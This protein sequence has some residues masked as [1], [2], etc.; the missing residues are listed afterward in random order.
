MIIYRNAIETD[1]DKIYE[2]WL[3]GLNFS[4]DININ[5]IDKA[6]FR[7]Y[8]QQRNDT[9]NYWVAENENNEIIGW[10]S[11]NKISGHPIK[12]NWMAEFS[13][14]FDVKLRL[15]LAPVA[16]MNYVELE[17]HKSGI[18]YFISYISTKNKPVIFFAKKTNW[19]FLGELPINPNP[20]NDMRKFIISK[21]I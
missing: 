6:E 1:F 4:F 16:L 18:K 20:L 3:Q 10:A 19:T 13:I 15:G 17:A 11:L 21:S 9:F 8:F 14:Y 2:I 5:N 7:S 12:K